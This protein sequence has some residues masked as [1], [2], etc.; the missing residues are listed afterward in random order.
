MTGSGHM[1][2]AKPAKRSPSATGEGAASGVSRS[3]ALWRRLTDLVGERIDRICPNGFDEPNVS[4]C[5]HFVSHVM[6]FEFG[7]TCR[8]LT[9]GFGSAANVRV[10]EIFHRCAWIEPW[11]SHK[12]DRDCLIF[13]S[14][15]SAF[16]VAEKTLLNIPKKHIGIV[17]NNW[18]F[19][20][21]NRQGAVLVQ[22]VEKFRAAF[23]EVY[24]ERQVL[25]CGSIEQGAGKDMPA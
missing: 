16:N 7:C 18:V 3:P 10:H 1:I 2:S 11:E 15:P 5:A 8:D 25:F 13:V 23:E 17:S 6:G 20:Y 21:S 24:A 12:Q 19:H 14:R 9:G 22:R 4:H